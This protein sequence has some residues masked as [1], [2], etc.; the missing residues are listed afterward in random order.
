MSIV[1]SRISFAAAVSVAGFL[2]SGVSVAQASQE[3]VWRADRPLRWGDFRGPV[4]KNAP[5]ENV[6]MTA[7]S[8]RW[9]YSYSLEWT[10][11]SCTYRITSIVTD[12]LFDPQ[13]SWVRSGGRTSPV[14][15]HEQGHFDIAELHKRMFEAA[16]RS[17][18]GRHAA[19]KGR[20]KRSIAKFVERD[21]DGTLGKVYERIWTN[22]ARM[23]NLYDSETSHG[24]NAAAQNRWLERIA[25]GLR[26]RGWDELGPAGAGR[27]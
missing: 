4:P 12:A 1:A 26:G 6:A 14:L 7:A 11:S 20:D 3:V 10:R 13:A 16:S 9:S 15:A 25:A 5:R 24:M 2:V 23:Q 21:I 19:C 18:M 8:L 27:P 17:F 22:Q